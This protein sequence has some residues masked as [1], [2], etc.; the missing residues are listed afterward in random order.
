MQAHHVISILGFDAAL[1]VCVGVVELVH[2]EVELGADTGA[3]LDPVLALELH[4][5]SWVRCSGAGGAVLGHEV[6]PPGS[7]T[8]RHAW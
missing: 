7:S 6:H 2:Q 3:A 8:G 5:Q 4:G 1:F